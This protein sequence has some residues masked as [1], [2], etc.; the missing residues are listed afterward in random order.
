MSKIKTV[1]YN[2]FKQKIL[3]LIDS[4]NEVIVYF[5][6][7]QGLEK[8]KDKYNREPLTTSKLEIFDKIEKHE[9]S[10]FYS[11][12]NV[13]KKLCYIVITTY[14]KEGNPILLNGKKKFVI[15]DYT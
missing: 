7:A 4:N 9:I 10:I 2:N 1:D 14:D 11:N 8:Q 12:D 5:S 3:S 6:G 15:Y 13:Y